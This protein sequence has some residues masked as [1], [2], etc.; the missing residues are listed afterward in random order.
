LSSVKVVNF[1]GD[2]HHKLVLATSWGRLLDDFAD[3]LAA[4]NFVISEGK[5]YQSQI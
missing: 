2:E 1:G 4:G 3:E 5:G